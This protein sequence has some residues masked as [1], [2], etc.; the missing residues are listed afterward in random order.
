MNQNSIKVS[1]ILYLS[2]ESEKA[3]TSITYV[4]FYFSLILEAKPDTRTSL[5]KTKKAFA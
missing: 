3:D 4:M 5:N 2:K 1:Y